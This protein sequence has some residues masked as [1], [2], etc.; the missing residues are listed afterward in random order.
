MIKAKVSACLFIKDSLDIRICADALIMRKFKSFSC[1]IRQLDLNSDRTI[2]VRAF[3]SH[4][5]D[6]KRAIIHYFK[7]PGAYSGT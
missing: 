2:T 1:L 5:T 7:R 6:R 3:P 4:A